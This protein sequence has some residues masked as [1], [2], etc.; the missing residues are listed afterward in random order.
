M[1]NS[2]QYWFNRKQI[3]LVPPIPQTIF[4]RHSASVNNI[5]NYSS[6]FLYSDIDAGNILVIAHRRVCMCLL[7]TKQNT[8]ATHKPPH[9]KNASHNT[10][11]PQLSSLHMPSRRGLFLTRVVYM[12]WNKSTFTYFLLVLFVHLCSNMWSRGIN[13]SGGSGVLH[14]HQ[15]EELWWKHFHTTFF[16]G[17]SIAKRYRAANN[18]SVQ[19]YLYLLYIKIYQY[20]YVVRCCRSSN[21]VFWWN[22]VTPRR[23]DQNNSRCKQFDWIGYFWTILFKYRNNKSDT[24]TVLLEI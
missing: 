6:V 16:S 24:N 18:R 4:L 3:I 1:I 5:L 9:F 22:Q 13:K 20:F 12:G 7:A 2:A 15:I 23:V 10:L 21:L 8:N 17:K 19:I 14:H 11:R